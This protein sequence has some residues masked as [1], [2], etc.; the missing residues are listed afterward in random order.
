MAEEG[1][2]EHAVVSADEATFISVTIPVSG[3]FAVKSDD[4]HDNPAEFF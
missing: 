1:Y 3:S 2:D 4:T